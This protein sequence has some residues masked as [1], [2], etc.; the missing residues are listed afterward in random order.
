MATIPRVTI[1]QL[2]PSFGAAPEAQFVPRERLPQLPERPLVPPPP[3]TPL[4]PVMEAGAEADAIGNLAGT[5][6]NL[7]L[8]YFAVR[9][10]AK[11][12]GI[13]ANAHKEAVLMSNV[14]LDEASRMPDADGSM[15][16]K[17]VQDGWASIKKQIKEKYEPQSRAAWNDLDVNRLVGLETNLISKAQ[18]MA[19]RKFVESS[20]AQLTEANTVLKDAV[21][22][23]DIISNGSEML[24]Y[25]RNGFD[26]IRMA[27][28]SWLAPDDAAR[29][30]R[31]FIQDSI[32][33][34]AETA[35]RRDPKRALEA[36]DQG[37]YK[38][39]DGVIK[40]EED[41][42]FVK[43]LDIPAEQAEILRD[44]AE[45]G[46]RANDSDLLQR[47]RSM[48]ANGLA[49][50]EETGAGLDPAFISNSSLSAFEKEKDMV[51]YGQALS[52]Y[53]F[54]EY[55]DRHTFPEVATKL[56][57]LKPKAG[58]ADF[59]IK[60]AAHEKASQIFKRKVNLF[61]VDNVAFF[62]ERNK[63]QYNPFNPADMTELRNQQESW[64]SQIQPFSKRS[65]S[66]FKL[67]WDIGRVGDARPLS[68]QRASMIDQMARSM[69][70]VQYAAAA[71]QMIDAGF[72]PEA[73]AL[74]Q[75]IPQGD[76]ALTNLTVGAMSAVEADLDKAV[77]DDK[78]KIEQ[79]VLEALDPFGP[80]DPAMLALITKQAKYQ[81]NQMRATG[82]PNIAKAVEY[83]MNLNITGKNTA[84][85]VGPG[86]GR[87][88]I[89][90]KSH[91]RE[92]TD[93]FL[94]DERAPYSF[95][96]EVRQGFEK[97]VEGGPAYEEPLPSKV[98][99]YQVYTNDLLR[100]L[101]GFDLA[102]PLGTG[103]DEYVRR[104]AKNANFRTGN[105]Q[106]HK[107]NAKGDPVLDAVGVP[108]QLST[109]YRAY[110]LV[111]QDGNDV[112]EYIKDKD[113][114]TLNDAKGQPSVQPVAV[115]FRYIDSKLEGL[116]VEEAADYNIRR[117][118]MEAIAV[119]A[120]RGIKKALE[121]LGEKPFPILTP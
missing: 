62:E 29:M 21:S 52:F 20:S 113:G 103:K 36:I 95:Y 18:D 27:G 97:F 34:Q 11:Q 23:V 90:P 88:A 85:Y 30:K 76:A 91:E 54:K 110:I 3:R 16:I 84:V 75:A 37:F 111:D 78:A 63:K 55:A 70:E 33:T 98:P 42:D 114:N 80:I 73:S 32:I 104:T 96:R 71:Q 8:Q 72:P 14:M 22:G 66:D 56:E 7:G 109:P 9:E 69:S 61:T 81:H 19:S 4:A 10:R 79:E 93:P 40:E 100:N 35:I 59:I 51:G 39:S 49:S 99:A 58:D 24:E 6:G 53:Q 17:R 112:V 116:S 38:L 121:T 47:E 65:I 107:R 106:L 26:N 102:L 120:I 87:K 25:L 83:V 28:E 46:A 13:I 118:K 45:A 44:K 89:I 48:I 74:A 115:T 1:E 119:G 2:P 94:P 67:V 57:E 5:I 108:I 82:W 60:D 92:I 12:Q 105:I 41:A 15:L 86:R 31:A 50:V 64:G 77:G 101:A 43:L 68:Q 117:A